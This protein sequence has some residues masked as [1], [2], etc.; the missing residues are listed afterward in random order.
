VDAGDG[1]AA[2]RV[3]PC[4]PR[5]RRFSDGR[6]LGR[7]TG[8]SGGFPVKSPACVT[9]QVFR[10]ERVWSRPVGLGTSCTQ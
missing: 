7:R 6:R 8:F 1:Q 5:T 9:V 4:P 3:K 2:V 10:G